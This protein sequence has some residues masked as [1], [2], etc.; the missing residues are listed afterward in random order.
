MHMLYALWRTWSL[1]IKLNGS[2][3]VRVSSTTAGW[4]QLQQ[5]RWT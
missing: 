5:G 4:M 1:L 2:S 3:I